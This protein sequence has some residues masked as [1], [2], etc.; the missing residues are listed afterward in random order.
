[1]S[2]IELNLNS[3]DPFVLEDQLLSIMH[4]SP[5]TEQ[6]VGNRVREIIVEIVSVPLIGILEQ[7]IS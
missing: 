6:F 1:M 4:R 3:F 7:K 2:L 5:H